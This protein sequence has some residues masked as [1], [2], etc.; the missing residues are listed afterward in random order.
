MLLL[1]KPIAC[2]LSQSL[3]LKSILNAY[4]QVLIAVITSGAGCHLQKVGE[5]DFKQA[6][7]EFCGSSLRKGTTQQWLSLST[8]RKAGWASHPV[9]VI[10]QGKKFNEFD[11]EAKLELLASN[12]GHA[13][14]SA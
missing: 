12:H 9:K 8:L 5:Q 10:E 3:N 1:E 4:P 7:W 11:R 13:L 6:N 14:A 2:G